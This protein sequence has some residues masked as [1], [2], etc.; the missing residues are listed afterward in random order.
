MTVLLVC[1]CGQKKESG[2]KA[3][4][5]VKTEVVSSASDMA[6]QTFVGIVE[7]SEGTA[8][9]FI[10]KAEKAQVI[11]EL[12]EEMKQYAKELNFEAAAQIRDA[13]FELKASK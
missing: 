8:V 13:I 1:S 11:M 3:P 10:T 7:E 6:G 5:R 9:S 4:T 12:E 2:V